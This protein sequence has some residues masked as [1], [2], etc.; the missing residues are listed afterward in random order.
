MKNQNSSLKKEE[1]NGS[2]G[3]IFFAVSTWIVTFMSLM[4]IVKALALEIFG[5][6]YG[7]YGGILGLAMWIVLWSRTLKYFMVSVA[8][9]T[10][11]AT[12]N[13]LANGKIRSYGPGLHFK[14]PWEQEKEGNHI[15]FR[16]VKVFRSETYPA[17]DGPAMVVKWFFQYRPRLDLLGRYIAVSQ[18]VIETGLT[19]VGSSFLSRTIAG[20]AAEDCKTGQKG[21][22]TDLKKSFD[23]TIEDLESDG[24]DLGIPVPPETKESTLEYLY[25]IHLVEVGLSDADYEERYQKA[26]ATKAIAEKLSE[27]ARGIK[28][29]NGMTGKD[30]HNA[31]LIINGMVAKNVQEVEGEGGQAI[32]ALLMAMARGGKGEDKS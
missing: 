16:L 9:I 4:L 24:A 22:E 12:I 25:G 13:L 20:I 1:I 5:I 11:L 7:G 17:K 32:A 23:R 2:R 29:K 3:R 27:T 8:E 30:S 18:D 26:R 19:D 6:E 15:N 14:Y 28:Q 21:I 10:G 31:A